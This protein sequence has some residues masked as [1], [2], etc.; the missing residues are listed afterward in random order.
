MGQMG[1]HDL[2]KRLAAISAK[3]DPLE[4]INATIPFESFRAKIEAVVR[5]GPEERKSKAGRKPYDAVLMFKILVLQTLYNLADEQLEYLIRDRLSFMRFLGL[6]LED[7]VP[8]AT[9]VWL[10]REALA[11]AGLIEELFARF[12]QHLQAKGYIARGGQIIDASIVAAPRQRNTREENEAIK[13]GETPQGWTEKPAKNAQKDVVSET[14]LRHD[15]ARWTKKHGKSFYG[16]KNHIGVD[17]THK[18][19][20][21][22]APTDASVHDSQ[23]LDDVLDQSNTGKDVWADSAYRSAESEAK[24][25]ANGYKSRVHTRAARNRPLS[26]RAKAANTTRSRVRARVEHVFGHQHTSM[27]G[28]IVRTIGMARAAA[29]IG[30]MNL[31]YNMQRLVQLER[32]AAAPA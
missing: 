22:Y 7:E 23:K 21:R 3:G 25:E 28:K 29:K 19:I 13:A 30:M 4:V 10:F 11:Q 2:D 32:V 31:V 8:D 5:L 17:R 9:T 14:R 18:L 27:G 1:F 15:D 24:L 26:Q 12:G 20:R 6:G 16:Y